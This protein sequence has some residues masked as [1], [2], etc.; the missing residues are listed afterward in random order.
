[1]V[2]ILL[3]ILFAA[4]SPAVALRELPLCKLFRMGR[5]RVET[6]LTRQLRQRPFRISPLLKRTEE[7]TSRLTTSPAR[8]S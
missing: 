4:S 1:M 5:S 7:A 8:P 2:M 6:P 3:A